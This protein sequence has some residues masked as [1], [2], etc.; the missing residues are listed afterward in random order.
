MDAFFLNIARYADILTIRRFLLLSR[1]CYLLFSPHNRTTWLYLITHTPAKYKIGLDFTLEPW[2]Y[3]LHL[4]TRVQPYIGMHGVISPEESYIKARLYYCKTGD[5]KEVD[6]YYS[7]LIPEKDPSLEEL[8]LDRIYNYLTHEE[9]VALARNRYLVLINPNFIRERYLRGIIKKHDLTKF[10]DYNRRVYGEERSGHFSHLETYIHKHIPNNKE[11]LLEYKKYYI[12]SN[13]RFDYN[14][15]MFTALN[16]CGKNV[17]YFPN[18]IKG[19]CQGG[20]RANLEYLA[21]LGGVKVKSASWFKSIGVMMLAI[22]LGLYKIKQP[23]D[24]YPLL[25]K[26]FQKL[27]LEAISLLPSFYPL[28]HPR[29]I[30]KA[31][32]EA[33]LNL[34]YYDKWDKLAVLLT[35]KQLQFPEI[36]RRRDIELLNY[37]RNRG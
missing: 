2:L 17:L 4:M 30:E 36:K 31:Y 10:K 27:E 35:R 23:S 9:I 18:C 12:T 22:Q 26:S 33:A 28:C 19:A 29:M 13:K 21:S 14:I 24:I 25:V 37:C 11:W 5:K 16:S 1:G 34:Y 8:D 7:R 32:Y 15:G 20:N 3:Y 6:E